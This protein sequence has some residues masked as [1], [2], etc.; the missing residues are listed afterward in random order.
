MPHPGL[1]RLA[2]VM[3][4][5]RQQCPWDARQ[6]HDSLVTYLVEEAAEVVEAIET[7][8]GDA[9]LAEELGD[10]LLQLYFHAEIAAE[11]GRF[12]LD[13]VA[14]GIADKLVARHPYVFTD[15]AVPDDL[16]ASWEQRKRDEKGR[17]SALD[18]IPPL[19]TLARAAKVVSRARH[20]A[21][22]VDLP[23]APV[24]AGDVGAGVL[25][26]VARA[27]ASGLDADQA[28]R[29]AVRALEDAVRRAEQDS[30]PSPHSS[31][32]GGGA[33]EPRTTNGQATT[34]VVGGSGARASSSRVAA[35]RPSS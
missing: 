27:Q 22:G 26:L 28:V 5:I 14:Q 15:A 24:S 10:L 16:D 4:A 34:R 20:L 21:V 3:H 23:D 1:E 6:T 25:S 30:R 13:D 9:H 8:S 7:A 32:G 11:G 2:E 18:G 33:D 12:T 19:A 29:G 17:G 31:S 35:R